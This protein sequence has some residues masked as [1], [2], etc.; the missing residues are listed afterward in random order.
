[1]LDGGCS[2]VR[3]GASVI[4]GTGF[5]GGTRKMDEVALDK[6]AGRARYQAS[7]ATGRGAVLWVYR[8]LGARIRLVILALMVSCSLL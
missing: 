1:M 5:C 8:W 7:G 3:R 4:R 6:A 2:A